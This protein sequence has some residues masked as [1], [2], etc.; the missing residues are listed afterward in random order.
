[1]GTLL[2]PALIDWLKEGDSCLGYAVETQ[3]LGLNAGVRDAAGDPLVK[4]LVDR[5]K[6]R[7]AGIPAL[8]AGRLSYANTGNAFWDLFFLAD[9]GLTAAQVGIADQ[10]DVLLDRQQPDGSFTLG[11]DPNYYCR[12][13]IVLSS[14]AALGYRDD[15]RVTRF[16]QH[17]F[18]EQR[19]D[20]GWH[21]LPSVDACPQ[22]NLN[23]LMLLGHYPEYR[24]DGRLTGAI[25]LL[26]DHWN[27]RAEGWR[28]AGFGVGERFRK[29]EYPAVKYGILRVLDVLS[30][31]PHALRSPEFADMLR[32][33]ESK[34]VDGRY[35]DESVPSGYSG[36][37]FAQAAVPSR[38]ITF[39]VVRVRQR[40]SRFVK[41]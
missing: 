25:D 31:F 27:R 12:S 16:V 38:W 8:A 6:S 19:P 13:A 9:V 36:F 1:M 39:I 24:E 15:P 11:S 18:D 32:F 17:V 5:L 41:M 21:C 20:G 4:S 22:D 33:V 26:L 2:D 23:V 28:P 14:V 30:R 29:L 35:R 34:A 7:H 10:V 40:A 37:D 3:L